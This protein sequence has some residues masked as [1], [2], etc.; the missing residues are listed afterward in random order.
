MAQHCNTRQGAGSGAHF[1]PDRLGNS[2][3][4]PDRDLLVSGHNCEPWSLDPIR[5]PACEIFLVVFR[6]DRYLRCCSASALAPRGF[7]PEPAVGLQIP[8]ALGEAGRSNTG[9]RA[10]LRTNSSNRVSLL[11]GTFGSAAARGW[12]VDRA[13]RSRASVPETTP[14]GAG[15]LLCSISRIFVCRNSHRVSCRGALPWSVHR[16]PVSR[17]RRSLRPS[18]S[19]PRG[20]SP[21]GCRGNHR[22]FDRKPGRTLVR[23]VA[24]TRPGLRWVSGI[25]KRQQDS[26][27]RASNR[28]GGWATAGGVLHFDGRRSDG[29]EGFAKSMDNTRGCFDIA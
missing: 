19:R 23:L 18:D 11:A 9:G 8:L 17:S 24:C 6:G 2:I 14:I 25:C 27:G 1:G 26:L 3:C 10:V 15:A 21:V 4:P 13:G 7:Q 29:L 5:S 12:S 16:Y 22:F 28:L 20:D